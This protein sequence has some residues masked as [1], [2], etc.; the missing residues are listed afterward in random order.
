M[1]EVWGIVTRYA[2][3]NDLVD[4]PH[5]PFPLRLGEDV[6]PGQLVTYDPESGLLVLLRDTTGRTL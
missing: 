1:P 6:S 3:A 2:K 5:L 4:L